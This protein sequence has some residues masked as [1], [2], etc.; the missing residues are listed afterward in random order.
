MILAVDIG[1]THVVVGCIEGNE[2]TSISR[3]A[4]DPGKTEYEYAVSLKEI[5]EF[6]NVD[7]KNFDGAILSSVVPPL[8]S[9]LRAAVK[10]VTGC[11]ALVV[12][13][14]IKTGLNIMID[15]PAQLGSDLVVG[16]VAA[17]DSYPVP[18]IIIDMGTATTF[19]VLD[20]NGSY[21]GGAIMPGLGLSLS[22]LSSGTSQLPKVPIEAPRRC[23]SSNTIDCMKSGGVFG[24]AAMLDGMIERI[25]DELGIPATV[26]ATGGIAGS[27]IPY[28]KR[29][30]IYD[31]DLLLRGLNVIYQKNK[32]GK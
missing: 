28:C 20:K 8:T 18:M 9:T 12:G 15:N 21:I 29:K 13:S 23:I 26:I 2:I 25:E 24:T 3:L 7:Y 31:G 17:L 1:N 30:I 16:A 6:C 5:F 22:A 4:S 14:G 11:Q 19:S 10:L 32:K 27:V